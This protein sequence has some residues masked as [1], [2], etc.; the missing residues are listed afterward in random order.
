MELPIIE[1]LDSSEK[2]QF[3][4]HYKSSTHEDIQLVNFSILE[5]GGQASHPVRVNLPKHV[6]QMCSIL[7]LMFITF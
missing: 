2:M 7:F 1:F 4:W 3:T 5:V 6:L